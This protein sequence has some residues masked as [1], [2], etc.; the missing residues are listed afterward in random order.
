MRTSCARSAIRRSS[1]GW[2]TV[3]SARASS[4]SIPAKRSASSFAFRASRRARAMRCA[5]TTSAARRRRISAQS[6]CATKPRA[7]FA[8]DLQPSAEL[9]NPYSP[10]HRLDIADRDGRREVTVRG[11]ARDVTLLVPTRKSSSTSIAMLPYAPGNED[12]FALITVTPPASRRDETTPRDVTLV[13]DVSG[14]MQRPQDRTGARRRPPTARHA[15]PVRSLPSD[16][17]LERRPHLPRRLRPGDAG[18]C[19]R[20]DALPRRARSA[21]VERT[22]K[23]R[24]AKHCA[25]RRRRDACRSCSSSPTVSRRSASARRRV[26]PRSPRAVSRHDARIFTFGLG[27]DVNVGLLEQLALDGRGTSQFVRPDES[28]ERMVGVVAERSRRSGVDRRARACRRRRQALAHAAGAG[29][30]TSSPIAT[31]SSSRAT[32]ATARRA[33]SSRASVAARRCAGNRRSTSPTASVRI[34]S[35][36]VCGRRSASA[37]SAPRSARTA[38]MP[39]STTRFE[40]LGERYGIP[41]E[42]TSYL[43][44]RAEGGD[45]WRCCTPLGA[46]AGCH[47][48]RRR[49]PGTSSRGGARLALRVGEGC[50]GAAISDECCGARFDD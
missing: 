39:R 44:R 25:R 32:P 42:F 18:E 48:D 16:R 27:A 37:S 41:T 50:L 47:A 7:S 29:D 28:V 2:A 11:D 8:A 10:T 21:A 30:R 40:S 49:Q 35:S 43:V 24:C 23:A 38:A 19:A 34:R 14:S 26:S 5:S 15:A 46:A 20:G 31:S 4:R 3:S 1:N 36:R 33:S 22:S 6:T 13:L 9:G 17:F 45:E 12:G